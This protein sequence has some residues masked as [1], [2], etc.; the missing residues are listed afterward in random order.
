LFAG[1]RENL[2]PPPF[3]SIF[4]SLNDLLGF[5]ELGGEIALIWVVDFAEIWLPRGDMTC[6][7]VGCGDE[8]PDLFCG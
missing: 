5:G 1:A 8:Y 2:I 3:P 4:A 7:L 6:E